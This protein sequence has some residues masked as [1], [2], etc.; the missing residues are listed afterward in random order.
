M[1]LPIEKIV[2]LGQITRIYWNIQW[3][4]SLET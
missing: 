4:N 2:N 3:F 1:Y